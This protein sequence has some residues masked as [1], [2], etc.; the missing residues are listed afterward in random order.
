MERIFK[1]KSPKP[2]ESRYIIG[3]LN[4]ADGTLTTVFITLP[5]NAGKVNIVS[6]NAEEKCPSA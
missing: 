2:D 5:K 3:P 6:C 4:L 1:V